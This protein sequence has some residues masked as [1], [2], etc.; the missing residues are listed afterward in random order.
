MLTVAEVFGPTLQGEGPS[1]GRRCAFVRLGGC[2]L[3]CSWCDTPYTWDWR[4]FRPDEELHRVDAGAVTSEVEAMGVDMLVITGGE[5]LLQARALMPLLEGAAERR[6]RVEVETNGTVAPPPGL[7]R[8]VTAFNVSPKLA[9]SGVVEAERIRPAALAALT[10][11]GRAVFKFVVTGPAD[12]DEVA[13]LAAAHRL[14]PVY[15]M[16]EGTTAEVLIARMRELA[17]PVL[18]HGF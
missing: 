16:P 13:A 2:N 1:V 3:D 6:W 12:L 9:N 17:G 4:R 5:P 7:A 14:E 8:L 10:A 15:V 11:T 18:A